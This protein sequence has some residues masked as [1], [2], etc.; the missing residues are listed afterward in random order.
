MSEFIETT[1]PT[2]ILS[3]SVLCPDMEPDIYEATRYAW[4]ASCLQF[5]RRRPSAI[6]I[7]LRNWSWGSELTARLRFKAAMRPSHRRDALSQP[8]M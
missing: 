8:A 1:E 2:L 7:Y 5:P 4:I 3:I 6:L